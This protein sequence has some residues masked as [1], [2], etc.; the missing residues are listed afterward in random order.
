MSRMLLCVICVVLFLIPNICKSQT[1]LNNVNINRLALAV[2]IHEGGTNTHFMFGIER[3]VNGRLIGYDYEI[4]KTK[5]INILNQELIKY[6]K[7]HP[8]FNLI[9][10]LKAVNVR[11]ASDPIWYKGVYK[12][13]K[14]NLTN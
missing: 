3:R 6:N 13:Y 14:K 8:N 9:D 5:C 11:Y 4:A 10:Y 1:N 2:F 7:I 12:I